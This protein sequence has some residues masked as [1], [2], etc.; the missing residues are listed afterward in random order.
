MKLITSKS[1]HYVF[2][3]G[4]REQRLLREVLE[5]YPLMPDG[6]HRY[7]RAGAT[8]DDLGNQAL[9]EDALAAHRAEHRQRVADLLNDPA[10]LAPEQ[11]SFRLSLT[12]EELEWLLQVL[13]E[14]RVGSWLKAGCPDPDEGQPPQV[15][16]ENAPFFIFM[17]VA[18]YFESAL[19][20]V[21]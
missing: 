13:N 2:R 14:V 9:L 6:Y 19:I 5:Q 11:T 16:A 17:E 7:S 18:A 21:L 10:R 20:E 8:E 4:K 1:G 15:T 12:R 3:L